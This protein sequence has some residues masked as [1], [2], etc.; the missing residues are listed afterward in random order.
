MRL[1]QLEFLSAAN[2]CGSFS[3]AAEEL[4]V[5]QPA[6]STAIGELEKELNVKIF[7]RSKN[8]LHLTDDGVIIMPMVEQILKNV[9]RIR[10]YGEQSKAYKARY[11]ISGCRFIYHTFLWKIACDLKQIHADTNVEIAIGEGHELLSRILENEVQCGIVQM[12]DISASEKISYQGRGIEFEHLWN[13]AYVF[14]CRENH[15]LTK[16][17]SVSIDDVFRYDMITFGYPPERHI[18]REMQ[19]RR[20]SKNL[21]NIHDIMAVRKYVMNSD[22]VAYSQYTGFS[23]IK[24]DLGEGTVPLFLKDFL[25]DFET[26]IVYKKRKLTPFDEEVISLFRRYAADL[27]KYPELN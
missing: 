11:R 21:V 14:Y 12:Y 13:D 10:I 1:N 3:K 26:C 7:V 22:A 23:T 6:V 5:T 9:D 27:E 8:G 18:Y 4:Y 20:Y 19:A 25:L 15:P 2:R 17:K 16:L 24:T